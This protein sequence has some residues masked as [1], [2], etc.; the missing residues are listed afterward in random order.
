MPARAGFVVPYPATM[1]AAV[2]AG[3]VVTDLWG[4]AVTDL[5]FRYES[6]NRS[7]GGFGRGDPNEGRMAIRQI[8]AKSKS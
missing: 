7:G 2:R 5:N 4:F 8:K 1:R 6:A 3:L